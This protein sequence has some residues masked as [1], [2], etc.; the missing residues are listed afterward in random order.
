MPLLGSSSPFS[1]RMA[2]TSSSATHS[3][4]LPQQ[5]QQERFHQ[6]HRG[7]HEKQRQLPTKQ[8]HHRRDS[9]GFEG[10]WHI[11]DISALAAALSKAHRILIV[12]G[13][14]FALSRCFAELTE[15]AKLLLC[16]ARVAFAVSPIA[17]RLTGHISL[18]LQEVP[19]HFIITGEEANATIF[20]YDLALLV[21]ANDIV[22]PLLLERMRPMDGAIIEVWRSP[23]VFALMRSRGPRGPPGSRRN[24]PVF[25]NP[26][27]SVVP[28]EAKKSLSSLNNA[29]RHLGVGKSGELRSWPPLRIEEEFACADTE[30]R[31]WPAPKKT[32]GVLRER[33]GGGVVVPLDP[34]GVKRLR[35]MGFAVLLESAGQS[36]GP[37]ADEEY[38]VFGAQ[39]G[40]AE[41][42]LAVADV[43]IHPSTP[44][45][46]C[47]LPFSERSS[48]STAL[49]ENSAA[50]QREGAPGGGNPQGTAGSA[51]RGAK[52]RLLLCCHPAGRCSA[53][54][55]LLAELNWLVVT[56]AVSSPAIQARGI[57]TSPGLEALRGY[58]AV[59]EALYALP[60]LVKG[61]TTAAGRIDPALVLVL[62]GGTAA[63]HAAAAA[64]RAGAKVFVVDPSLSVKP[65]VE[66]LG[67]TFLAI[68]CG[69]PSWGALEEFQELRERLRRFT[70][71]SDIVICSPDSAAGDPPPKLLPQEWMRG[72]KAGAVIVDLLG[73]HPEA[74]TRWFGSVQGG[75]QGA[76]P[77]GEGPPRGVTILNGS[78]L[79]YAMPRQATRVLSE[80]VCSLLQ[81]LETT[82]HEG[83]MS[84]EDPVLRRLV[85]VEGGAVLPP[86]HW[87][88]FRGE[89]TVS[90]VTSNA[91]SRSDSLLQA[92]PFSFADL[93]SKFFED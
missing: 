14:G 56:L 75:P 40:T 41:E 32:V 69:V 53:L 72:M 42:I 71:Q 36:E 81:Q 12:P 78:A 25:L 84:L 16:G 21:G 26:Q 48:S 92:G 65:L 86:Q 60:R 19:S 23:R 91:A 37:Y 50:M 33:L 15:I 34:P 24:N 27:V 63:L 5:Q 73:G 87:G 28:G 17:G 58:R 44:P 35:Q 43:V 18:Y 31:A 2:P 3:K 66:S 4:P 88:I 9:H 52:S 13:Y 22:N 59:I 67:A 20:L 79:E 64:Y 82:R 90:Q 10:C 30:S 74:A 11:S 85:L 62:G 55:S 83:G 29:L 51:R 45:L 38:V 77:A 7:S 70:E 47:F 76:P 54:L 68:L 80:A 6:R 46:E 61:L 49:P 89:R 57:A 93:G 8:Q 39:L 1:P